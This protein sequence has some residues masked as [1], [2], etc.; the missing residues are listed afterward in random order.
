MRGCENM[1]KNYNYARLNNGVLEY[2]P[3]KLII[4]TKQV[5]NAPAEIYATQ[6]YLPIANMECP[7][8]EGFY[9]TPFYIETNGKIEQQWE[10]HEKHIYDEVVEGDYINA[11]KEKAAAYDILMG[12]SE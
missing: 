12:A 2:A 5:F 10:K 6:G 7:N 1:K 8:E 11:F 4:D 3:N 9:F